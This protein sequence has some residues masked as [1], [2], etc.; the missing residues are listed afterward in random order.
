MY[1]YEKNKIEDKHLFENIT[2]YKLSRLSNLS[3]SYLNTIKNGKIVISKKQYLRLKKIIEENSLS[4]I[5]I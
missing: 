1:Y 2:D 5:H 3:Q 4:L